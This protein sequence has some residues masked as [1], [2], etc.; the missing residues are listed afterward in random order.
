M[1]T[2]EIALAVS[3]LSL[4]ISGATL[5]VAHVAPP[6]VL[7]T[8]GGW[9][10]VS[11]DLQS[12]TKR[13][14]A[15]TVQL[16][17]S[18]AGARPAQVL[19]LALVLRRTGSNARHCLSAK[20]VFDV[21][22]SGS[23]P[24]KPVNLPYFSGFVVPGKGSVSRPVMFSSESES[25]LQLASGVYTV[26]VLFRLQEEQQEWRTGVSD[27]CEIHAEDL[28]HLRDLPILASKHDV[29]SSK[30]ITRWRRF[31]KAVYGRDP[32]RT[33]EIADPGRIVTIGT[34]SRR[35]AL[36][37][38]HD[39]L[40]VAARL[41]RADGH[42]V[43]VNAGTSEL[44]FYDGA[45]QRY[46]TAGRRG[47]GPGEYQRIQ[48]AGWLTNDSIAVYDQGARRVSILA[49]TGEFVRSIALRPPFEGGGTPTSMIPLRTGTLLV[50]FTEIQRMAPQLE[51]AYFRQRVFQYTTSGE[52]Q[53]SAGWSLASSEHF[54]QATPPSMGGV[55]YWNLAF[56]RT[57]TL[58]PDSG[59]MLAGDGTGWYIDRVT[60]DGTVMVRYTVRRSPARVT[61]S[62]RETY[63]RNAVAGA[64]G[65]DREVAERMAKEMP[66][67]SSKPAY[68]RFEPDGAGHIWVETYPEYGNN[69]SVWLR[70][71]TRAGTAI[72]VR[73]PPQFLP[74]AFLGSLAYG[75]W[76]DRDDV[77]HLHVYA[78][79]LA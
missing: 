15:C 62:D 23:V 51:P 46:A 10:G 49:P 60:P 22:P 26:E 52:I 21:A 17:L 44:W 54:I 39:F 53:D 41:P 34:D 70:I 9:L 14:F 3:V 58:R 33:I 7:V 63:R 75:I 78:I 6:D 13:L 68:R 65:Q 31:T 67:P 24:D 8:L 73:W 30:W 36:G 40:R 19:D 74:L 38:D 29:G 79:P 2:G 37:A 16:T 76:R 18:N 1:T 43:V 27:E 64:Q 32:P 69:R 35:L 50:G 57:M 12:G 20:Y 25:I 55:A 28:A 47:A 61:N 48:A 59:T 11:F 5:Y 71:D 45:G 77:E 42:F 56:G 4:A 66:F 72:V